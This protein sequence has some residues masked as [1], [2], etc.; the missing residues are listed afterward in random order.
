[1]EKMPIMTNYRAGKNG[2][3]EAKSPATLASLELGFS[4]WQN[5]SHRSSVE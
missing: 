3:S 2:L 5:S 1:M 4:V